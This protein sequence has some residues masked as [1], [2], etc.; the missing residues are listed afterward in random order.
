MRIRLTFEISRAV[1]NPSPGDEPVFEHQDN[2]S[3]TP[4][5]EED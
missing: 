2:D 3:V 1:R 4:G 5:R